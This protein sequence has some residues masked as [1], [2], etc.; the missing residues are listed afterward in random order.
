MHVYFYITFA[1][2]MHWMSL[3]IPVV[4]IKNTRH[5][6]TKAINVRIFL[7]LISVLST[8]NRKN[9]IYFQEFEMQAFLNAFHSYKNQ[10]WIFVLGY[11]LKQSACPDMNMSDCFATSVC[12]RMSGADMSDCFAT[13]VCTRTSS[14]LH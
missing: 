12:T 7:L 1:H 9:S 10:H 13:S 8:D 14:M 4:S 2:L 3:T 11:K 5:V 6:L